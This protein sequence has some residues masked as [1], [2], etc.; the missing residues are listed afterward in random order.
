MR[1]QWEAQRD[2]V[3]KALR[4]LRGQRTRVRNS[5]MSAAAKKERGLGISTCINYLEEQLKAVQDA[6]D[7][8]TEE[9][10]EVSDF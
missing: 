8:Y 9:T 3:K 1:Q 2:I 4:Y 10:D 6:I 7:S 5:N